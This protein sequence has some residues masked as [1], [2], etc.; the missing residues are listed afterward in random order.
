MSSTDSASDLG[1]KVASEVKEDIALPE[2]VADSI[3]AFCDDMGTMFQVDLS[4][5]EPTWIEAPIGQLKRFFKKVYAVHVVKAEGRLEGRFSLLVDHAGLFI[6]GGLATMLPEDRIAELA[7][8]GDYKDAASVADALGETGNLMVGAWERVFQKG[9]VGHRHLSK[10]QT[11]IAEPDQ[12]P[13]QL[14]QVSA[15]EHLHIAQLKITAGSHPAF[16]L[17]VIM[18]DSLFVGHDKG[19]QADLGDTDHAGPQQADTPPQQDQPGQQAQVADGGAECGSCVDLVADT[20]CQD[21]SIQVCQVMCRQVVWA[22]PDHD[23]QHVLQLMQSKDAGYVLIGHEGRLEGIVSRSSIL[24]GVSPYLRP[25]FAKWR[26]PEDDATLTIRIKWFM[27]KPVRT[28]DADA[29]IQQAAATML[30]FGVRALPV[31]DKQGSVVGIL[32][33]FDLL[34]SLHKDLAKITPPQAP[35]LML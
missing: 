20:P 26:R 32:T 17:A 6:L 30:Q 29:T 11:I 35:G 4:S 22:E 21:L 3:I 5:T 2:L 33:V 1:A 12:D 18:P 10:E 31:V 7:K 23:I 19:Q 9:L 24:A 14:L 34:R 27:S 25:V 16:D 15:D 8:R 28:V 13:C